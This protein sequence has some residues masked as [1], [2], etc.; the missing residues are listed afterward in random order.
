MAISQSCKQTVCLK[1]KLLLCFLCTVLIVFNEVLDPCSFTLSRGVQ[2]LSSQINCHLVEDFKDKH[3]YSEVEVVG[4]HQRTSRAQ[5]KGKYLLVLPR[6]TSCSSCSQRLCNN[7]GN[8]LDILE[9]WSDFDGAS[10]ASK[11]VHP[12]S[13]NTIRTSC[14]FFT[15]HWSMVLHEGDKV[16]TREINQQSVSFFNCS[17]VETP[18]LIRKK[19]FDKLSFRPSH[20]EA[21]LLDFFLRSK[22]TLKFASS[23]NCTF[24]NEQLV[25]DRGAMKT[26]E[27]YLDYGLLGFNH[28]ILRIIRSDSITW[29]KC[30]RNEFYCPN[31]PL[32]EIENSI[33]KQ[34]SL[35]CCD[36]ALNQFLIDAVDG[37]NEVG[38]DYRLS[39]GTVLGAVRSRNIIPWTRDID[40]DLTPTDYRDSYSFGRLKEVMQKKHYSTPLIYQLRR[41]MPLFPL[42]TKLS[43][44]FSYDLFNE[45]ILEL[46]RAIL[47]MTKPEWN[48][49]GYIDIYPYEGVQ[50]ASTNITINGRQ[51][52]T[53]SNPELYL[54]KVFGESW[55]Q[56]QRS[57]K[58]TD[59]HKPWIWK[60]DT[61]RVQEDIP[62]YKSYCGSHHTYII[63][64]VII[65]TLLT[66]VHTCVPILSW[67]ITK[68]VTKI[69]SS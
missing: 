42:R 69:C 16:H 64:F 50:T 67:G 31:K 1:Y 57:F 46:M 2:S 27:V 44:L 7:V 48:S 51:Y 10:C 21:T 24:T 9:T 45:Q 33:S 40:I 8:L 26:T 22:G 58:S 62:T 55:R 20:G 14:T 52:K 49:V 17:I 30:I 18:F 65:V 29:T 68:A 36:V 61:I 6:E 63:V 47:P 60:L 37:L 25:V 39:Y 19:V 23:L 15:K 4:I 13:R 35:F 54:A 11:P 3:M 12:D 53:H 41:I 5:G 59:P 32:G 34:L 56:I 38:L 28:N 43:N 66:I